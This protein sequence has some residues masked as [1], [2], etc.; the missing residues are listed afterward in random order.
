MGQLHSQTTQESLSLDTTAGRDPLG[1]AEQTSNNVKA[2]LLYNDLKH[3]EKD[4]MVQD[5]M[6]QL[7]S[8]TIRSGGSPMFTKLLIAKS[9]AYSTELYLTQ[10]GFRIERPLSLRGE[11]T[12]TLT[13]PVRSFQ[14]PVLAF[15]EIPIQE[16]QVRVT[17]ARL[18][19]AGIV[20][21]DVRS[22]INK[23][24]RQK[25]NGAPEEPTEVA[26]HFEQL[27]HSLTR[28][29]KS[30]SAQALLRY[31]KKHEPDREFTFGRVGVL[32][33]HEIIFDKDGYF[34]IRGPRHSFGNEKAYYS[35]TGKLLRG[36]RQSIEDIARDLDETLEHLKAWYES[37]GLEF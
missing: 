6:K 27:A 18:R 1:I 9:P 30:E 12:R 19:E 36:C 31:I 3:A 32:G 16:E 14:N 37:R 24:Y 22:A 34:K 23:L 33:I 25:I 2:R 11:L 17:S 28:L 35:A 26:N 15:D 13:A 5:L 29:E 20:D 8:D 21:V 4:P 10:D 7:E